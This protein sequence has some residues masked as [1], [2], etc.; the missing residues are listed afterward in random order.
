MTGGNTEIT[1]IGENP[2][3]KNSEKTPYK[4][5]LR[6]ACGSGYQS[7]CTVFNRL[8]ITA[9]FFGKKFS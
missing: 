5:T 1:R 9:L 4:K 3:K 2:K 8:R 6:R 7:W